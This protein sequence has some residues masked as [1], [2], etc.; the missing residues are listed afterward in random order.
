MKESKSNKGINKDLL[1][2]IYFSIVVFVIFKII[3]YK[4][5]ISNIFRLFISLLIL[6]IFP[7]YILSEIFFS[8]LDFIP[9]ILVGMC[10]SFGIVG[11]FGYYLGL[12]G[13]HIKYF[14]YIYYGILIMTF[15]YT[16]F[17]HKKQESS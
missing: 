14:V 4:E 6:G 10:L 15:A 11:I 9:K 13:I 8:A 5:D 2:L 12:M 7:A 3:F 17:M 1:Y 16:K